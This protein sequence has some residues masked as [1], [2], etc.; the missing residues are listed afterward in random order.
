[1]AGYKASL[2]LQ[3][4]SGSGWSENFYITAADIDTAA[5]TFGTTIPELMDLRPPTVKATYGRV[6]DITVRGDS[7]AIATISFPVVGTYS[8]PAGANQIE[9]GVALLISLVA[10]PTQKNHWFLR[11]LPSNLLQGRDKQVD[12]TWDANF[13]T[14]SADLVANYSVYAKSASP[15]P[16]K[17]LLIISSVTIIRGT[18]RR[19]GRPFALP[20]GR[21]KARP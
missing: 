2:F 11:G 9:A 18:T 17:S 1:M 3:D 4:E 15:P 19:V 7:K 16:P 21:R 10:T 5:N 20:V 14:V 6:S 8:L 13:G 12:A